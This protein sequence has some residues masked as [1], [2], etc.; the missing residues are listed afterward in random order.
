MCDDIRV[1][2]LSTIDGAANARVTGTAIQHVS[3]AGALL[4]QWSPFDHFDIA[5]LTAADRAPASINW[6]HGNALEL[7]ADRALIVSFRNLSEITKIDTRTGAIVWRLGG[8]RNQFS[9]RGGASPGF[10]RQHGVRR[11]SRG[12]LLLLDNLGNIDGSR[13]ERYTLD[14]DRREAH[15]V[16]SYGPVGSV[17]AQL[18]GTTQD[19]PDGHSLVSF[20]TAGR[21]EEYDASGAIVWQIEGNPGYVF[22]AQRIR[23]LY[24]PS[25]VWR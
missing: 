5:D 4:F 8:L 3:A 23:S 18:G 11:T 2:D 9:F 7:D 24:H 12:D 22:R 14:P 19:L 15:L 16:G 1:M 6:T 17:T 13:A 10:T 25:P 20:G 21:V